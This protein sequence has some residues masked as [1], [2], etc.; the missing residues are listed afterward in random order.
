[1]GFFAHIAPDGSNPTD[2]AL[3]AGWD[4]GVGENIAWSSY[5]SDV[6]AV[7]VDAW[8]NSPGHRANILG[9]QY[10]FSGLGIFIAD[11]GN[12][13]AVQTFSD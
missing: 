7:L 8:M 10:Q 2:R 12:V 13:F 1:E 11:N 9:T 5:R 6:A 4:R 3:A